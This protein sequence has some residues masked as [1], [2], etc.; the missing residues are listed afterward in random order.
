M[1]FILHGLQSSLLQLHVQTYIF[2]QNILMII[3]VLGSSGT[4][5]D[6][7]RFSFSVGRG[8]GWGRVIIVFAEVGIRGLFLVIL[9]YK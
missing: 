2:Y 9:L 6:L 8:V 7:E 3:Y 1:S 5:A 4:C